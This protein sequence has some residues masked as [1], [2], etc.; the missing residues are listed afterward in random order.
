[1]S[2]SDSKPTKEHSNDSKVSL[3]QDIIKYLPSIRFNGKKDG[4]AF[5]NGSQGLGYYYDLVQVKE[6]EKSRELSTK[7]SR[8]TEKGWNDILKYYI[9]WQEVKMWAY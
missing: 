3:N 2:N 4:Y 5:K 1:M 6:I 7:R 9:I 8:E